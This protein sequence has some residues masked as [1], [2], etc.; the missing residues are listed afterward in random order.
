MKGNIC[1]ACLAEGTFNVFQVGSFRANLCFE[2]E[3]GLRAHLYQD[4]SL[5]CLRF[6]RAIAERGR[7]GFPSSTG[8]N[9]QDGVDTVVDLAAELFKICCVWLLARRALVP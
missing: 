7:M 4:Y 5:L 3:R 2:C 1:E 8:L 6:E 9:E